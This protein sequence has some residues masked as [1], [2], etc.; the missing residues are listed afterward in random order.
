[1][2]ASGRTVVHGLEVVHQS[3]DI[4]V[5]HGDFL[6]DGDLIPYLLWHSSLLAF[7]LFFWHMVLWRVSLPDSGPIEIRLS[8]SYI[9]S[10]DI[11][12]ALSQPSSSY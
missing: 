8:P 6:Q 9:S 12:Y 4:L 3:Q 1:M 11:P 10:F 5:S 7:W 2:G